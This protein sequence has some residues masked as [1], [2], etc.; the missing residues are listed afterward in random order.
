MRFKKLTRK[1]RIHAITT[2][3]AAAWNRQEPIPDF[4]AS[5]NL[6]AG[7]VLDEVGELES[8]KLVC[9]LDGRPQWH[10]DLDDIDG[11][12]TPVLHLTPDDDPTPSR[13]I[14]RSELQD[15]EEARTDG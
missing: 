4:P 12:A 10:I 7:Y 9:S 15:D 8:L 14:V 2:G 5:T 6:V 11:V 13:A 1:L 3:A